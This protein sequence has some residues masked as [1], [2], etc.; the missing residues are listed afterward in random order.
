MII[1]KHI[2]QPGVVAAIST[3]LAERKINIS[4]MQLGNGNHS[5][6]AIMVLEIS[7][8]VDDKVM[9]KLQQIGPITWITQV[10]L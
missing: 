4:R 2:D 6:R 8:A 9:K 7:E 1:S 10:S 3:I 5:E